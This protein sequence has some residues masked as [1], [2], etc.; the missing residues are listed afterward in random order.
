MQEKPGHFDINLVCIR[1]LEIEKVT[2]YLTDNKQD[3]RKRVLET[4][5]DKL[6]LT[7]ENHYVNMGRSVM[8]VT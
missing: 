4:T 5:C 3:D 8:M 2:N 1:K 6:T 7:L